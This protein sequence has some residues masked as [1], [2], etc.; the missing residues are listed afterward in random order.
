MVNKNL[1]SRLTAQVMIQNMTRLL[2]KSHLVSFRH[3]KL[4]WTLVHPDRGT[5]HVGFY[6][7]HHLS[8][9][10]K[11]WFFFFLLLIITWSWTMAAKS[12][13]IWLTSPMSASNWATLLS[14]SCKY[15]RFCS[16]SNISWK[17]GK[18]VLDSSGGRDTTNTREME[19]FYLISLYD[20]NTCVLFCPS[21]ISIRFAPPPPSPGGTCNIL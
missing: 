8:L 13:K 16:S 15:S 18:H 4:V 9:I 7:V 5:L 10:K 1:E 2:S 17:Q 12:L 14:L 11:T 21:S 3:A 20:V 19:V 6:R